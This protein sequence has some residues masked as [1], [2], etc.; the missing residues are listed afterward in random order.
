MK[1]KH[2]LIVLKK[3]LK[4]MIRDKRT[5]IS[6]I[7]I[8]MIIIPVLYYFM[9]S[10]SDNFNKD[11]EE[12][13]SISVSNTENK[14]EIEKFLKE[15]IFKNNESITIVENNDAL[16]SLKNGDI[17]VV[18]QIDNDYKY[19][20]ENNIP[21]NINMMYDSSKMTSSGSIDAVSKIIQEYNQKTVSDRITKLGVDPS[22]LV[23][24][25]IN[26][27][28]VAP[29]EAQ[30][31][32]MLSMILPMLLSILLVTSGAPAAIDLIVGERERKTFESLLTT[33]ANRFSILVGKYLAICTFSLISIITSLIGVLIGMKVSPG[34]FG[35]NV[36]MSFNLPIGTIILSVFIIV[37]FG[38]MCSAV[39]LALSAFAKTLK[40]G[41]TYTSFLI[42]AIMIPAYATMFMQ[43]GDVKLYMSFIPAL[44]II[45]LIKM[46]L[47]SMINYKYLILTLIS[48]SLYFGIILTITFRLFKKESIVIR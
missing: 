36:G 34:M 8:P 12:N 22:I 33:K 23:P 37:L 47:S 25:S 42:F 2:I 38:F 27:T 26:S 10:S 18:L 15:E 9:G 21:I 19:K 44:N 7:L 1:I 5:L 43:A 30:N 45:A 14:S 20:L 13:L 35:N 29:K 4:D 48:S 31:N 24:T 40:E 3:E 28:D 6:T 41:Q 39:Q 17:R 46:I 16:Q 32:Q 11:I